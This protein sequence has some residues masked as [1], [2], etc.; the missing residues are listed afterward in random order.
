M[1]RTALSGALD[2]LASGSDGYQHEG[3]YHVM[4]LQN[5]ESKI[6]SKTRARPPANQRTPRIVFFLRKGFY[7][8]H[9]QVV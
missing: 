8:F 6:N 1:V 9:L 3:P 5:T 2:E 7:T 4:Y